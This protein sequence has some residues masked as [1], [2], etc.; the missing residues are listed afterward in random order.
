MAINSITVCGDKAGHYDP[1][2]AAL[3]LVRG[4]LAGIGDT[5][6]VNGHEVEILPYPYNGFTMRISQ[7]V[8]G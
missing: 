7:K 5:L 6:Y 8:Q 3:A 2:E 4:G 1:V